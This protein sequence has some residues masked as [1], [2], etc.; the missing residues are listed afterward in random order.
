MEKS[1]QFIL[2]LFTVVIFLVVTHKLLELLTFLDPTL[3]KTKN[4][5]GK[6]L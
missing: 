5:I 6:K 2:K 1:E 3:R 4:K